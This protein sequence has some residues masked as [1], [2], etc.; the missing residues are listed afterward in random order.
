MESSKILNFK[1]ISNSKY[2]YYPP[3]KTDTGVYISSCNYRLSKNEVLPF[4]IETPKLKT[5]SGIIK[6][7]N[8]FYM[9]LE[10]PLNE[11]LEGFRNFLSSLD[12]SHIQS[13]YRNNK[14]WFGKVIPLEVIE[15]YYQS[16]VIFQSKW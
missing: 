2:E 16:P 12:E 5:P 13:C 1:N 11:E 3:H 15:N 7:G 10:L 9:D 6:S 4:Y 14:E 8:K